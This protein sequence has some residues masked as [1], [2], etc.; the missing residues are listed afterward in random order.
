MNFHIITLFPDLIEPYTNGSM[1][2]RA[3]KD[4]KIKVQYYNPRNYSK[5]RLKR[6]DDKPYGG[7]P[8]MVMEAESVL[9]ATD[10]AIGRKKDV[11]VIFFSPSGKQFDQKMAKSL[12]KKKHVVMLSGHYEGIDQ[13]A[14]DILKATPVSIGP[15]V[16]TGGE[17][18]AAIIVDA[19]SR[20]VPGVLG[21]S[22]SIEEDRI[23]SPEVYTRPETLTW[24]RK[25]YMVPEVLLSGHH[26]KIDEWKQSR[27]KKND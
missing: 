27:N 20:H 15:Y 19:V 1:L 23:S 7:G 17:L 22:E 18:P 5:D 8:G 3:Q 26:K 9:R 16:L 14:V 13:R 12:S 25:K 21:N 11:E 4:G 10:D 24:K 2:G 6:V